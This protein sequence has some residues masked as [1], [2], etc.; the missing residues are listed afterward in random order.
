VTCRTNFPCSI[1]GTQIDSSARIR[2]TRSY[3]FSVT[4]VACRDRSALVDEV[5]F[6]HRS[7]CRIGQP[8]ALSYR[9]AVHPVRSTGRSPC[10]VSTSRATQSNRPRNRIAEA[11]QTFRPHR[12]GDGVHRVA[13]PRSPGIDHPIMDVAAIRSRPHPS[14]PTARASRT[15]RAHRSGG[16]CPGSSRSCDARPGSPRRRGARSNGP[17]CRR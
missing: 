7:P 9:T 3:N 10:R 16:G 4:V 13:T 15:C 14:M 2:A 6:S 8:S 1:S 5:L 12:L 11:V 17:R